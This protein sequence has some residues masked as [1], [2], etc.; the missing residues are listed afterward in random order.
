M[1]Y[2]VICLDDGSCLGEF[3]DREDAEHAAEVASRF[4][5]AFDVQNM[6][7]TPQEAA[8][9]IAKAQRECFE[10][11]EIGLG[12]SIRDFIL[13]NW[14]S[15]HSDYVDEMLSDVSLLLRRNVY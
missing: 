9:K 5:E 4:S 10:A 2:R 13:D 15:A 8:E 12:G 3:E 11:G 14:P 6:H 7:P 1:A